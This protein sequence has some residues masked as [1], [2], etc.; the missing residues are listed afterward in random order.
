VSEATAPRVV[1]IDK[2]GAIQSAIRVGQILP[3]G[4]DPRAFE[5]GAMNDV[6]GGNFTA[7][8]NMNLR[9]DKGWTYGA[10]SGIAEAR[11]P[12]AFGVATSV[13][14]DKTA[15]ALSEIDK[16]LRGIHGARPATEAE[17]NLLGK[18]EVL[19]LPG[20]FETNNA[21]VGYLQYVN[22]FGR[23]YNWITTLPDAYAALKPETITDS[24]KLLHPD[25]MTWVVVGDL[26]RIEAKVRALK[27]GEVEVWDTKGHKLR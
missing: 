2:P 9:E 10:S 11:G 21:M 8:L 15:E 19:S 6:L 3:N 1:L 24:A 5:I 14:T 26:S 7:R 18:G 20:R 23:P 16:E 13:Q 22:R 27:L 25:R 12:Q 4:S 17:L